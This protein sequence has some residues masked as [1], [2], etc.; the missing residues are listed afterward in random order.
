MIQLTAQAVILSSIIVFQ[1][2]AGDGFPDAAN[3]ND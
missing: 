2:S 3:A 1:E